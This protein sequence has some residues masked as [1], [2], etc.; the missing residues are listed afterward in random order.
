MACGHVFHDYCIG[1]AA[2]T[3]GVPTGRLPSADVA[4]LENQTILSGRQSGSHGHG[5]AI[6]D[7]DEPDIGGASG[8]NGAAGDGQAG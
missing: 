2:E 8:S 1:M 6:S 3:M 4:R 7:E 5:C